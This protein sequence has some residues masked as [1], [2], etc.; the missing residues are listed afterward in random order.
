MAHAG[1]DAATRLKEYSIAFRGRLDQR[2]DEFGVAFEAFSGAVSEGDAIRSLEALR[3]LSHKLAGAAGTFGFQDIGTIARRI[4]NFCESHLGEG[5]GI[6]D[7]VHGGI[8]GLL[9][10]LRAEVGRDAPPSSQWV[11]DSL[12]ERP[13]KREATTVI[14]VEDDEAQALVLSDRL[15]D[16]GF[17]PRVFPSPSPAFEELLTQSPPAA[18]VMDIIIDGDDT[19]GLRAV[20]A[21]RAKRLLSCPVIMA[22]VRSDMAARLEAVRVGCD[23]YLVKPIDDRE[24]ADT[25]KRVTASGPEDQPYRVMIVDDDIATARFYALLLGEAGVVTETVSDPMI[26]LERLRAFRP[27]LITMDIRM[28]GCDG[29]ELARIIRQERAFLQTPI[30]F[31]ST[32]TELSKHRRAIVSGGDDILTKPVQSGFLISSVLARA[33][34]ARLLNAL[35]DEV[36]RSR[37]MFRSALDDQTEFICRFQADGTLT[38]VNRAFAVYH[39]WSPSN[40]IGTGLARI[41]P[42]AE[43]SGTRDAIAS[44]SRDD[45]LIEREQEVETIEGGTLWKWWRFRGFFDHAGTLIEVQAVGNDITALKLQERTLRENAERL[46]RTVE[47][48]HVSRK[49]LEQQAE[50]QAFLKRKA[51]A[52]ERSKSEFLATMSH[53]IRTPMTGVLGMTDLLLDTALTPRQREFAG[54]IRNSGG[55]LLGILNDVLDISKLEA[56]KVVIEPVDFHFRKLIDD[57]LNLLGQEAEAK[58]LSLTATIPAGLPTGINAD[59]ARIRQILHNL[60]GNAIKFTEKGGVTV[61]AGHTVAD[62]GGMLLRLEVSD[63]GIGLSSEARGRLFEKFEQADATTTRRYGGTG[64]G[65]SICKNLVELMGGEIGVES[66]EGAGSTFWFALRCGPASSDVEKTKDDRSPRIFVALRRLDILLAEDN[67]VN[68]ALISA[69]LARLG[70]RV[71]IVGDGAQAVEAVARKRFDLVLMDVRMPNKD[72]LDATRDIRAMAG[73]SARIPIIGVT[74]DALTDRLDFFRA[75]GM[76]GIATKPI[77][78]DRLLATIDGVLGEMIHI[79]TPPSAVG[80]GVRDEPEGEREVT[81]YREDAE[82]DALLKRMGDFSD[83]SG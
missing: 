9:D 81:G 71:T 27:D 72:G 36:T 49:R 41:L 40:M 42:P 73:K 78:L 44:L 83:P 31:L 48:L 66:V 70:H 28:P 59:S 69:V 24:L 34:R 6:S 32:E 7:E 80:D 22:S 20:E 12:L 4:E 17:I 76:D 45:P 26:A 15:R 33:E 30:I 1:T 63:T 54:T 55:A 51:E 38:F 43:W 18:V 64:L 46:T 3:N 57:V 79:E 68:Q 25:V 29:F 50:E 37:E 61:R 74:A 62:D 5:F 35:T 58:G 13:V 10:E 77:D 39:G 14:L 56:G 60:I 19:A 2:L 8:E 47:E 21:L 82:L 53:E 75:A 23:A 67:R 16:S 11:A 65:L 52:A